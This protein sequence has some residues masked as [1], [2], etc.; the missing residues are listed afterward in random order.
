M[1][2]TN[3]KWDWQ[4]DNKTGFWNHPM[5]E[6]WSYRH[7]LQG[8]VR[9]HFLLNYQQ[10]VLGP[11]W[12]LFQPIITLVTY[13][14]VFNKLVGISTGAIPPVVFY[15]SGVLLWSFFSDSFTGTASTFRENAEVFGKVYFPRIIMPLSV[16]GI[17][18]LRLAIQLVLFAFIMAYYIVFEGLAVPLSL[19]L[20][21]FPVSVLLIGAFGLGLG[22]I[23]SV[24][25]AK[26]RDLN[27]VVAL[28][29]RLM[30]FVTPVIYP[31]AAIP[32]KTRW[33]VQ[34]NPLTPLFETFRLSLLGQGVVTPAQFTYS[35]VC[36]LLLLA[37]ALL[38][39]NKQGD[40]LI[41]IV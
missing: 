25:T 28:G 23:F 6:I 20:A 29:V 40:K 37:G 27:N 19:W 9:R 26:Y 15:A 41:D 12:V 36:T 14:F 39:F 7:L 34:L 10:T 21:A 11:L 31:L 16:I 8:L 22:L 3:Q 24:L 30:M 18:M 13:L 1:R 5:A 32:E 33:I 35:I 2:V 17:Y 38:V 4:V